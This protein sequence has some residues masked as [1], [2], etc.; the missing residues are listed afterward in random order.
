MRL[1]SEYLDTI[2]DYCMKI[3]SDVEFFG[4]SEAFLEDERYQRAVTFCLLQIGEVV[5]HLRASF[6]DRYSNRYWK[7][8]AGLRDVICHGY[9]SVDQTIIWAVVEKDIPELVEKC[10][11]MKNGC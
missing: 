9:E 5:K 6:G 2:L 10:R 8:I 11:V 3:Q 1:E 7:K 4:D